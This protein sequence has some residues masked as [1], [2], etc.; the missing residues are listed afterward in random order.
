ME[1][2]EQLINR[3]NVLAAKYEN[4][5]A[6]S[7]KVFSELKQRITATEDG[8]RWG[9][10]WRKFVT[11]PNSGLNVSYDHAK[12]LISYH[13]SPEKGHK[14]REQQ[15]EWAA[16]KRAA[17]KEQVVDVDHNNTPWP[18]SIVTE[19][20]DIQADHAAQV[21]QELAKLWALWKAVTEEAQ[22]EFLRQLGYSQAA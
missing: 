10:N 4:F 20:E 6:S 5:R 13:S 22:N 16:Q 1:P 21:R 15:K 3:A 17:A 11:D 9:H 8:E 2:L 19:V 12:R 7:G 14:R 18:R